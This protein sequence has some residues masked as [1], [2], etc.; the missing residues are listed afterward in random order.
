MPA[1]ASIGG[2]CAGHVRALA[3][4]DVHKKTVVAGVVTPEGQETRTRGAMTAELLTLA[5]WLLV[6]SCIHVATESTGAD[7]KPVF[8]ILE[9]PCEVVL[10]DAQQGYA[11]S[12]GLHLYGHIQARSSPPPGDVTGFA[13]ARQAQAEHIGLLENAAKDLMA[14]R[15]IDRTAYDS[16]NTAANGGMGS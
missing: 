9:G 15:H 5:D 10:V 1:V 13:V 7:W 6:C 11:F 14:P 8:N 16:D 12:L 2:G 4:I 3:G